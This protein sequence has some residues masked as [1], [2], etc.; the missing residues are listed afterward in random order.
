MPFPHEC[1]RLPK[2][3]R[4]RFERSNEKSINDHL[5]NIVIISVHLDTVPAILK[6][7][8]QQSLNIDLNDLIQDSLPYL[9]TK[10]VSQSMSLNGLPWH[11]SNARSLDDFVSIHRNL[12]VIAVLKYQ[13]GHID[14]MLETMG[15]D[16]LLPLLNDV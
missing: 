1:V 8:A 13:R 2:E 15:V 11:I 10:W 14:R 6:R 16:S 4:T 12:V 3:N 7:I 5:I 9:I